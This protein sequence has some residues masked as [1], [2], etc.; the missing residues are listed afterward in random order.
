MEDFPLDSINEG[1]SLYVF[2]THITSQEQFFVHVEDQ[3]EILD[4]IMEKLAS[5]YTGLGPSDKPLLN[6]RPGTLCAAKF[7]DDDNW[8]RAKITGSHFILDLPS[9]FIVYIDIVIHIFQ[10]DIH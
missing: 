5:R 7:T 9:A 6:K 1:A 3:V 8:Y 2:T 10:K 4:E